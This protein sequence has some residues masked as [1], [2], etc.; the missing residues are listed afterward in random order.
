MDSFALMYFGRVAPNKK[1]FDKKGAIK[2][3]ELE[4]NFYFLHLD[5][6]CTSSIRKLCYAD[7]RPRHDDS[8]RRNSDS[9]VLGDRG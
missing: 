9:E 2:K 7:W 1:K 8:E 6:D 5:T 3:Y 4:K